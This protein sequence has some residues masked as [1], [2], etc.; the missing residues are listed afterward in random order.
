MTVLI[1][2]HL[3]GDTRHQ[4]TPVVWSLC[5]TWFSS[6]KF[7]SCCSCQLSPA[8]LPRVTAELMSL[9]LLI[10][11]LV[12]SAS[13]CLL[14]SVHIFWGIQHNWQA[15]FFRR[16][17]TSAND[18]LQVGDCPVAIADNQLLLPVRLAWFSCVWHDSLQDYTEW[19]RGECKALFIS[20]WCSQRVTS[21]AAEKSGRVIQTIYD[22]DKE[23]FILDLLIA[24]FSAA[25]WTPFS[26]PWRQDRDPADVADTSH[27]LLSGW[28]SAV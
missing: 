16:Q 21:T 12:F 9:V 13:T 23:V 25:C 5:L 26:S 15:L 14:Y 24:A 19:R 22:F 4:S 11:S 10:I 6:Y 20:K 7:V 18:K 2:S 8:S 28:R 27:L 1:L 3:G 17:P